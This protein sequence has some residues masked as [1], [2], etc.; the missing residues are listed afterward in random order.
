MTTNLIA[1][2]LLIV[3]SIMLLGSTAC[4]RK[5]T[6]PRDAA[7]ERLN[8][9]E[10]QLVAVLIQQNEGLQ[11]EKSV[12]Q[13]RVNTQQNAL[14]EMGNISTIMNE[15]YILH[16][17]AE[18]TQMR[19]TLTAIATNPPDV[20]VANALVSQNQELQNSL[21][22]LVSNQQ[23]QQT[24]LLDSWVSGPANQFGGRP[25]YGDCDNGF[26]SFSPFGMGA[27]WPNNLPWQW[28][29]G[30]LLIGDF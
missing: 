23:D 3:L 18:E 29:D 25:R 19:E 28:V 24:S 27:D 22:K 12:L 1:K 30:E 6:D 4:G 14:M 8:T 11:A 7:I 26:G 15:R 21:V 2:A 10:D 16:L 20:Q 17:E 9:R 5:T 13:E